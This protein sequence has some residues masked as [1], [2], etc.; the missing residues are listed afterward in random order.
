MPAIPACGRA[1]RRQGARAT[2]RAA[3][4]RRALRHRGTGDKWR[5]QAHA[6][7]RST[8]SGAYPL[9]ALDRLIRDL[10]PL[11]SLDHPTRV[12]VDLSRLV[13]V[14]P[15]ALALLT[16]V[17]ARGRARGLYAPGSVLVM[18]SSRAV[19]NYLRRMDLLRQ[20]LPETTHDEPFVRREAVGFRPCRAFASAQECAV[21]ARD[22]AEALSELVET[23][24]A[25]RA[26]IRICLD[27]LAENVQHAASPLGGFAAAQGWRR[28]RELE[29]AIVDLGIGIR[30]S[31]T[32]NPRY[33]DIDGDV[34]AMATA[35]EPRV[36]ATPERNSGIGLFVTRLLLRDN[37]GVL[38]L[39]S[40]SGE[41]YSGAED[42]ARET[43]IR[44][45]GTLVA[46][47]ARTDRPL[48]IRAVYGRLDDADDHEDNRDSA[49]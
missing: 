17:L 46:L 4:A 47:R 44:F 7:W 14:R 45:P 39:R 20:V 37:G 43:P 41:V 16:A 38:L 36:T 2:A 30:A 31:L 12:R 8:S 33:A 22:L 11:I 40:G 1:G 13:A 35:L 27:E 24:E 15:A 25:A 19:S 48:D 23:D 32:K 26:S 5:G 21:V 6:R 49:G 42:G 18:P 28:T 29:I 34:T 3:R 9:R 10:A